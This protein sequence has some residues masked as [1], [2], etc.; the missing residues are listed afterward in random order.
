MRYLLVAALLL[1]G[2]ATPKPDYDINAR[3]SFGRIISRAQLGSKTQQRADS[4]NLGAALAGPYGIA[5][6]I[7]GSAFDKKTTLPIFEF[8]ILL[9]EGREVVAVSEF[10]ETN[11]IG[12]CVK[13][14]ESDQPS[15][16]RFIPSDEC[17]KPNTP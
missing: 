17:K 15:Y 16:P 8:R 4:P 14:F 6:F 9:L 2:C 7:A 1:S 11:Q 3:E 13:V 12:D 5:G 10:A